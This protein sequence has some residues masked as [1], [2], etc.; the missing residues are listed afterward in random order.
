MD[1]AAI[2]LTLA[3]LFFVGAYLY[4][5]FARGYGRRVTA[6]ERELSA[7][8]A[9]RERVLSSLQELDFDY[10]LGKIPEDDYPIQRTS[11][12]Q[13]GADILRKMDALT[14]DETDLRRNNAKKSPAKSEIPDSE[15]EYLISQRRASRKKNYDGFCPRCGK[16]VIADDKFCASCGKALN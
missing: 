1:I 5:P 15:L 12:L 11:L 14:I 6:E 9:E 4:A 7:L 10:K 16:P 2:F 3:V 13:K 8:L